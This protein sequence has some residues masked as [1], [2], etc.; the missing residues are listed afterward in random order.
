LPEYSLDFSEK[1]IE[2]ASCLLR[3]GDNSVDT[4][5]AILYLSLL[6]CEII[7]KALLEKAGMTVPEI[8]RRS[9]NLDGLLRDLGGCEVEEDIVNVGLKW[10][11]AVRVRS[12]V[13]SENPL[14][15]IGTFLE[16]ESRG[17]SRYPNDIRYGNRLYHFPYELALEGAKIILRW[18]REKWDKIRLT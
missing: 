8:K 15:T 12:E 5:R 3:N 14:L 6:S 11:K 1:L 4:K 10:V 16:G 2:A 9:H 7:M 17:A 13:I 18:A